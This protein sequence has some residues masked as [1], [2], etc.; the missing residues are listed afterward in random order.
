MEKITKRDI[1]KIQPGKRKAFALDTRKAI[2]SAA[3]YAWKLGR[4][5][6]REDVER[7]NTQMD[8]DNMTIIIEAVPC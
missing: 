2:V 4:L 3:S 7:Y 8:F 5:K 1:M 6:E